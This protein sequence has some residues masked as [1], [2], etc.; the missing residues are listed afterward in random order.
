[1]NT[2]IV[3]TDDGY[4]AKDNNDILDWGI[5]IDKYIFKWVSL[6]SKNII[7]S[8]NTYKLL[9]QKM[10]EDPDRN[11]IIAEK[12][13][14]LSLEYL[15]KKYPDAL[16]IGGCNF[17]NSAIN[18]GIISKIIINHLNGIKLR[19]GIKN[20]INKENFIEKESI[21]VSNRIKI[22]IYKNKVKLKIN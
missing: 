19:K 12:E 7:T 18:K 3:E 11:I 1:M 8:K 9:P 17:I 13:G 4:I 21:R 14:P 20:T 10:K 16:V 15:Y 2:I 6:C 5:V 22:K